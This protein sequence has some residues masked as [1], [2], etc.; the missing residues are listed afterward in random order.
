[1]GCPDDEY[2]AEVSTIL[3]RVA[4]AESVE[5]A[6]VIVHEEFSRWFGADIA[7]PVSN[8]TAAGK[9]VWEAW[10]SYAQRAV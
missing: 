1:M 7:G 5:E 4:A 6:T 8:Y 3:P 9:A 2:D 10:R